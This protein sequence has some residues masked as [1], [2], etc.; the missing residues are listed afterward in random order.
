M[1]ASRFPQESDDKEVKEAPLTIE[2]RVQYLQTLFSLPKLI[3]VA[4]Y[5]R[6]S[7]FA[8]S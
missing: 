8:G 4:P 1:N 2:V 7:P 5:D 3:W 6:L